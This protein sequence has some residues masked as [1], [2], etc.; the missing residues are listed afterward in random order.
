MC[1]FSIFSIFI[2]KVILGLLFPVTIIYLEFRTREELQ[3]MP[4]TEEEHNLELA[5]MDD[6]VQNTGEKEKMVRQ[7]PR[8]LREQYDVRREKENLL[9]LP[10]ILICLT[11]NC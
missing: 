2:F 6:E 10:V 9:L 4:Q 11:F 1:S 5:E 3:L 7:T 8:P